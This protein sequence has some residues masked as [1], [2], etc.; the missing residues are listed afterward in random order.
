MLQDVSL[1]FVGR[2]NNI[3]NDNLCVDVPI[4]GEPHYIVGL[5]CDVFTYFI[6]E[7][8]LLLLLCGPFF[9]IDSK[10]RH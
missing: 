2:Y 8:C 4:L 9:N 10:L 6:F 7:L 1:H 3:R 5:S